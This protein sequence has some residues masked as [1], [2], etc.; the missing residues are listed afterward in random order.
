MRHGIVHITFTI[1]VI[2]QDSRND[3][4]QIPS[5]PFFYEKRASTIPFAGNGECSTLW[6]IFQQNAIDSL[7]KELVTK[8]S[9]SD[10]NEQLLFLDEP[11]VREI[12]E[13][14]DLDSTQISMVVETLK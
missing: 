8:Y 10:A 6:I 13:Q 1:Q 5:P 9:S 3:S 2:N 7:A 11:T 12:L 14:T 4:G